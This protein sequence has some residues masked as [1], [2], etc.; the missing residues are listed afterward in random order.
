MRRAVGIDIGGTKISSAL[1]DESGKILCKET[2]PTPTARGPE[3]VLDAVAELARRLLSDASDT[4]AVGVGTAGTV[5]HERGVV[6]SATENIP[7]W[8]GMEVGTRLSKLLGLP[9]F[10]DNDVNTMAFGEALSDEVRDAESVLF[11]TVGTGIGGAVLRNGM[12]DRGATGIAGEVGHV[13]V[14]MSGS[15][16]CT[17]GRFGHLEAYATGPG[18]VR[19]YIAATGTEEKVDLRAVAARA[20]E[21]DEAASE[22]IVWGADLFGRAL[23]G[24][25][26]ILDPEAVVVGGGVPQI[27]ASYWEPMERA[28]RS[29]ALPGPSEVLLLPAAL[30]VEAGMVGAARMALQE[31][32]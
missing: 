30:G 20:R 25:L 19:H 13:V 16:R 8:A 9:V 6:T 27:G 32:G 5:D 10:V 3:A 2:I 15:E 11:V 17:C 7:G 12:L 28:L 23:G 14:E 29:E 22:A 18:I 4:V 21:A 31:A 26:N 24:M 1:V